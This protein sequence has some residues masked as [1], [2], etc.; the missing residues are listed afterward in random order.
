MS[1]P[2]RDPF[3]WLGEINKASAVMTVERGIVPAELGARIA[4]AV[5]RVIADGDSPAAARSGNYLH[6]EQ[7]LIKAGGSDVTRLHS[8]RSRQDIAATIQRTILRHDFLAAFGKLADARA[9]LLALAARHPDAIIPAYTWGVQAQ[10][11]TLGHY[12]IGYAESFTRIAARMREAYARINLSPLGAAA[13]GTSSFPVDRP[14]LAELLGFDGVIENAFDANQ[15]SPID[16]GAEVVGLVASGALVIGTLVADITQQYA[17][18]RPWLV[19]AEGNMTGVSSIMPQKRNPVALVFLR[20]QAST[21][22]GHAQTFLM[23]A[24]NT[25]SGMTDTKPYIDARQGDQPNV[26]VIELTDLYGGFADVLSAL[27]FDAQRAEDEVDADYSTTTELADTLQRDCDIAFRAGHHFASDLVSFGRANRLRP[28]EI[29]Y[30]QAQRIFADVAR[31]FALEHKSLPLTEP[32]FRTALS[33]RNMVNASR[34]LGGPQSAEVARMLAAEMTRLADDRAW[35]V[36][37]QS[38]LD[39]ARRELDN[40]FGRLHEQR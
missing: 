36:K 16:T 35:L 7:D 11:I 15:V 6:V 10:P 12:L 1:E 29:P 24:H 19:L 25:A 26:V 38:S 3:Y 39:S 28:A 20:A 13:L 21:V 23:V 34:G 30:A 17:Q 5:S 40:A 22:L 37:T 32:Q 4:A 27:Q 33:A 14:R 9:A 18:P 2:K 31:H 8:G